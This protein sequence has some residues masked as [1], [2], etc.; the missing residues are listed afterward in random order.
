MNEDKK[1]I[2]EALVDVA[3]D[4]VG[5]LTLVFCILLPFTGILWCVKTILKMLGAM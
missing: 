4:V 1:T 3:V 2:K 5:A